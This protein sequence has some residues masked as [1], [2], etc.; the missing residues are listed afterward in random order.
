MYIHIVK[1]QKCYSCTWL[2][3]LKVLLVISQMLKIIV[4]CQSKSLK[5]L[6]V[7]ETKLTTH[8][9]GWFMLAS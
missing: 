5:L 4:S 6:L 1:I 9:T 3:Y 8:V 7:V 2:N